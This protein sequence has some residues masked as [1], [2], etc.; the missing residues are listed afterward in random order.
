[1]IVFSMMANASPFVEDEADNIAARFRNRWID[2]EMLRQKN[3]S[4]IGM[5]FV[6]R[7]LDENPRTR[8]TCTDALSHP[9]LIHE[10]SPVLPRG[11]EPLPSY[12]SNVAED[13]SIISIEPSEYPTGGQGSESTV[14]PQDGIVDDFEHIKMEDADEAAGSSQGGG[15]PS[16]SQKRPLTRHPM[17]VGERD[18]AGLV[19]SFA[20]IPS[21]PFEEGPSTA[22][23]NGEANSSSRS[24]KRKDRSE[25]SE[26]AFAAASDSSELTPVSEGEANAMESPQRPGRNLRAR[27][28]ATPSPPS[29]QSRASR[30][31]TPAKRTRGVRRNAGDNADV[32]M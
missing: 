2:W 15:G 17:E 26:D 30:G 11:L 5:D 12:E 16:S 29:P 13:G 23:G 32:D 31:K 18:S 19:Q 27:K 9:W 22:A 21:A 8:M 7:L 28:K 3:V 25:A 24:R 14:R 6:R 20:I 4:D 10:L 1:M